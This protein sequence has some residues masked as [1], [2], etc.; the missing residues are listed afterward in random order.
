MKIIYFANVRIPTE[1]AHGIQIMKTLAAFCA[2][3]VSA[4]LLIPRRI[5]EPLGRENPFKFYGLKNIFPIHTLFTLDPVWL[6]RAPQGVYIKIQS[7]LF[8]ISLFFYLLFKKNKADFI[9]YT[10]EEYL[11]P[12]L[13]LFSQRVVWEGHYLPRRAKNYLKFWRACYKL[14]AISQT[15]KNKLVAL[16]L[17]AEKI[18]VAHDGVAME[19]YKLAESREFL[20]T[21]LSLPLD[22]K[23]ILYAGH[24]YEWKGVQTLADAAR[25]LPEYFFVFVG[26]GD[27]K[28]VAFQE[29]N[30]LSNILYSGYQNPSAI[31]AYLRAADVLVLPNSSQDPKSKYTSPLKL[32]EYLA[33]GTPLIASDL[34]SLRE[35]LNDQNSFLFQS[36]NSKDLAEKIVSIFADYSRALVLAQQGLEDV[37]KYTW[38]SRATKIIAFLSLKF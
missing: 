26:G 17:P 5:N 32:F 4:E 3:G 22:K 18:L 36:D 33:S 15:L 29:G 2:A 12:L 24:F 1:K 14:V 19:N 11:L 16:S 20:R 38:D 31:P 7:I 28:F 9:F 27:H 35:I 8:I 10:R 37:K 6:L 23:I 21:K 25:L 13:Q 30:N 34:P